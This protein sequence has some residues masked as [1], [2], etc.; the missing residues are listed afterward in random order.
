[1]SQ[2]LGQLKREPSKTQVNPFDTNSL[3]AHGNNVY[4]IH[5]LLL[6]RN[7]ALQLA[8]QVR[9]AQSPMR[10]SNRCS[11]ASIRA[12]D[13][14][15]ATSKSLRGLYTGNSR[16]NETRYNGFHVI[17]NAPTGTDLAQ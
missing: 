9:F 12:G 6:K 13:R 2:C 4:T 3:F 5:G 8:L 1:M 17:T 7:F 11:I 16:H 14:Q 15:F 10:A